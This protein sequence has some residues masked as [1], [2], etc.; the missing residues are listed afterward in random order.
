MSN[1]VVSGGA[2]Y[3][4][5]VLVNMLV[6]A[7]HDVT[8]I[9]NF[10]YRQIDDLQGCKVMVGDVRLVD[11]PSCDFYIPLAG[12]VGAPMCND[13]PDEATLVNLGHIEHFLKNRSGQRIIYPTT[14]SGY[15]SGICTEASPLNPVSLY[16]RLKVSAERM[17]LEAGE[18]VTLRLATV[19]GV[20]PCMRSD[21]L[22]NWL[23]LQAVLGRPVDLYESHFTRNYVHVKDVAYAFLY[24]MENFDMMSH[25]NGFTI[26]S[27]SQVTSMGDSCCYNFGLSDCNLSKRELCE[28][29][30]SV[31]P[32][33]VY[34]EV[35]GIKDQDQRNYIVSNEKIESKGLRAEISLRQ[36]IEELVLWYKGRL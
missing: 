2:G 14:N 27:N 11:I 3:I 26:S 32:S 28:V 33:F 35:S 20:S 8:V 7:G 19:F 15:G 9:G 10:R 24:C 34:K 31:V 25:G 4:G 36:G 22:V 18:S 6:K 12:I 17:I 21:L 1:I 16:G 23:V 29:I 5:R 30:K 13:Y